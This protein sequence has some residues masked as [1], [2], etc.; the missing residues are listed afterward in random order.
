MIVK[1]ICVKISV[2][3]LAWFALVAFDM[4]ALAAQDT[5]LFHGNENVSLG[6]GDTPVNQ[7]VFP[8]SRVAPGVIQPGMAPVTGAPTTS[9]PYGTSADV[10]P[11]LAAVSWTYSPPVQRRVFRKQDIVTIR[12]DE[13]ARVMAEGSAESRKLT[14]FNA[15]VSEWLRISNG[16]ISPDP[17]ETGDP[18]LA[19]QSN[20]QYRAEADVDSRESL[21]FNIAARV[22]DI[23]PNGNLVLE[24]SKAFRVNDNIWETS[25]SGI[26]RAQ[27]VGPDNV[28]LSRDM[29]DVTINKMDQGQLRDGYKRGWFRRWFDRL[30]P[31]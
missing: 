25:L 7:P 10:H 27:D 22:V 20:N 13:I 14:L 2:L 30:Q 4:N 29:V 31:F 9:A 18:T 24:G 21:T 8:R 26:C 28:V 15:V 6:L 12:V 16:R 5:S 19:G 17:Q 23:R 11:G 3:S 1:T